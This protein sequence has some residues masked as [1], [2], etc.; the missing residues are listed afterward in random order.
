[1]I[2]I[3]TDKKENL[4]TNL[5]CLNS[6]GTTL[7]LFL[8][9]GLIYTKLIS[10]Y[11]IIIAPAFNIIFCICLLYYDRKKSNYEKIDYSGIF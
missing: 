6:L 2:Q 7:L 10:F 4:I 8:F 9:S 5:M 3:Q 1:M 11:F